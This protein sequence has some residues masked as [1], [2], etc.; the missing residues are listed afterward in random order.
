MK[1]VVAGAAILLV[2]LALAGCQTI[3]KQPGFRD[4]LVS[5]AGLQPGT[6]AREEL[7]LG[8][9]VDSVLHPGDSGVITVNLKDPHN[10]VAQVAGVVKEYPGIEFRL[11]DDGVAPD[12]RS[13]DDIW[14]MQV[15]VPFMA[16]PGTF[17]L[18]LTAYNIHGEEVRIRTDQGVEPLQT[19]C[20][21]AIEY[22]E[23]K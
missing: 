11:R 12:T 15:D 14:S 21:F 2:V 8:E 13:N 3:R 9:D 6:T 22:P 5:P 10:V 16:P 20:V 17:T 18:V 4:A 23:E 19:T 1:R 7:P